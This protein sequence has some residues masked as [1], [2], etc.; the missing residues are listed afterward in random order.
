MTAQ[1]PMDLPPLRGGAAPAA[2]PPGGDPPQVEF[3]PAAKEEIAR[4]KAR[5]P[6]TEAAL[7]P[8]LRV[9]EKEFGGLGPAAIERVA[10]ELSLSPAHVLGV[11]TF[12]THFRREGEGKYVVQV[13][14]TISCALRGCREIVHYLEDR[15]GIGPGQT[16]PDGRFTLKKVE[17]LGSCGTAPVVQL[18]DDY[19][20]NLTVEKLAEILEALP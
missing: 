3:S 8:V 10:R 20:E 5:Y 16:T 6:T 19:L 11:F 9:A 13:C 14:A 18:N 12:Y 7:L 17:C 1:P 15:L 2:S 4:L